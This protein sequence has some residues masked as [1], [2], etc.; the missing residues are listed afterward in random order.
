MFGPGHRGSHC[1]SIPPTHSRESKT[2]MITRHS[3]ARQS[4]RK[5]RLRLQKLRLKRKLLWR[6]RR[7][8]WVLSAG[9]QENFRRQST[10]RKGVVRQARPRTLTLVLTKTARAKVLYMK[11]KLLSH[12]P[13]KK[14][15]GS[16]V[17]KTPK[18]ALPPGSIAT[19]GGK[20]S[21]SCEWSRN[22]F[23]GRTGV[24]GE[25][26]VAF[27]FSAY[28]GADGARNAVVKWVEEQKRARGL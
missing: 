3:C 20:P 17:T 22:Q 1:V 26:C 19:K 11:M 24:K 18:L 13:R 5:L 16:S 4:L 28:G 25:K 7:L 6:R 2:L 15:G 27:P 8:L 21:Y 12:Q 9:W 14:K 23:M 10:S